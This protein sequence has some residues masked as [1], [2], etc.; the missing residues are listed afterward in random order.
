[1][2]IIKSFKEVKIDYLLMAGPNEGPPEGKPAIYDVQVYQDGR[3]IVSVGAKSLEKA[4][5]ALEENKPLLE[6]RKR[7]YITKGIYDKR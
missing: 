2:A 1:M 3:I 4:L 7:D 6:Q 5:S